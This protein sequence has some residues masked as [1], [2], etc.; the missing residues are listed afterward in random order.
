MSDSALAALAVAAGAAAQ[1]IVGIGFSLVCAPFLVAL[2]GSREGVRTAILLSAVLNFAMLLRHRREARPRDALWLLGPALAA[3]PVFA[4]AVKRMP[5]RSLEIAA[6]VVTLTAVALL[7]LGL[8]L[9]A[10]RGRAGAVG[11]GVASAATNVVAGIG[12]P[13]VAMWAVNADWTPRRTRATLQLY[14]LCLNLVALA[15]LGLPSPAPVLFAAMALGWLVGA[16]L[17]RH[18]SDRVAMRAMLALAAAGAITALV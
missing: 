1:A 9:R 16:V 14:F 18:V 5:A 12:G 6:G 3:T 7:S 10:A 17:D 2:E 11:A 15:G 8:R 13:P 4:A